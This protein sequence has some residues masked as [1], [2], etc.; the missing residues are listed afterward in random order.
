MISGQALGGIFTALV[1]IISLATGE[2]SVHSAFL[3]FMVGNLLLILTLVSYIVLSKTVFFKYHLEEKQDGVSTS[4][5]ADPER[6]PDISYMAIFDKIW[7]YG[8]SEWLVF[9]ITLSVYPGVTVLIESQN[10]GTANKWS[11]KYYDI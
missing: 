3:Y 2:S 7:L 11:G 4:I 1:Q 8:V 6:T 9:V 5:Q 10:K